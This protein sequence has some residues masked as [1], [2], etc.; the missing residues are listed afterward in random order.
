MSAA[1]PLAQPQPLPQIGTAGGSAPL[2]EVDLDA[3]RANYAQLRGRYR[4]AVLA[5]VLK[6]DAYG[7]GLEPV[8]R[9][10][11]SA[12]CR[13]FWVND[14]DEAARL[15]AAAPDAR[16]YCLMGLAGRDAA[17]FE[18]VGAV[19]ALVSLTEIEHCA[20]HAARV[21]RRVP[22]A[23][24][25]DTGLGRLGLSP[26]DAAAL[27]A[28]PGLL[29]GLDIGCYVSHL[30]AYNLPDDPANDAQRQLLIRL[31]AALPPA[32]VSLAASS[33]VYM[34]ADWHFDMARAG[35]ALFGVQT[36]VRHQEGLT[37]CYALTAPILSVAEHPAGR[38]VG[39][40][41]A[42]EL[43]RRSRV[44]TVAI[45]Y[46]NGLPQGYINVS[47]ARIGGL[48]APLV[49]GIAMNMTMLDVTDLPPGLALEGA[50]AAFFDAARTIEHVADQL[51]CAPNALLTQIG[52]GT[53]KAYSGGN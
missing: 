35:S 50:R 51:G 38:R 28:A 53:R 17:D 3:V 2:L 42:T 22:V 36:S 6:S 21:G 15:R 29:G 5:A 32:P 33:G 31:V 23:I 30:A 52:A 34:G 49:G 47:A 44:A 10:L 16:I 41:G 43:R 13:A 19:P 1:L 26:D 40:R 9:A 4:G 46:A 8:A 20:L 7:L 37:P 25:I 18:S 14:L 24:Q 48:P 39:Y 27:A 11:R 12:G 45:G